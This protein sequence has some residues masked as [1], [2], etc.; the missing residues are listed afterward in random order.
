MGLGVTIFALTAKSA[1]NAATRF[2]ALKPVE[3]ARM[4][5]IVLDFRGDLDKNLKDPLTG[6]VNHELLR[7]FNQ[8]PGGFFPKITENEAFMILGISSEEILHLDSTLLKKKHRKAMLA[9]HPDK[10]GSAYIAMK[11]NQARETLE[12]SYLLKK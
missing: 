11:I 6:K 2:K 5:N 7:R 3:I 4:N 1:I 12:K 10:G 8:Y 9:N